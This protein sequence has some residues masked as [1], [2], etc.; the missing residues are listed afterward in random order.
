MKYLKKI[1]F[2]LILSLVVISCK[3]DDDNN[4]NDPK[5]ENLKTLGASAED[6]LSDD[7]Y[8][9]LKVEFAYVD[10]FRPKQES[11]DL[12]RDLL[13]QRI[14][15]SGGITFVENVLSISFDSS[16]TLDEIKTV[17]AN[18][19][20]N[21]TTD[22]TIALY[23]YFAEGNS[24]NDTQTAVT[25][26]TAYRNTSLVVYEKTLRDLS[27]SQG[28]DLGL[29]ESVTIHHEFGHIL[30]LVGISNDDIHT[31]HEDPS[32]NN[33]CM[34]SDCL[35]YFETTR[36]A[37]VRNLVEVPVF[38]ELCIEDLQAKGGK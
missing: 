17:E 4:S 27:E 19:R 32:H 14:N 10:G 26:G 9:K 29:L 18:N 30:G 37:S 16:I 33:H 12:F 25:L 31:N 15:K 23:I 38:D 34:V 21:Y 6:V 28:T 36:A 5:S 3:N 2:L 24:S 35:M 1:T 7:I 13:N 22:N 8:N 11:I 20:E